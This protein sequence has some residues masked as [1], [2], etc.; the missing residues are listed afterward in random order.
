[1]R[2]P[3]LVALVAFALSAASSSAEAQ[4]TTVSAAHRAAVKRFM[5]VTRVRELTEQSAGRMLDDQLQQ[6]P[7]LAPLAG[8]LRDFYREQMSWTVLEPEYTRIY[9]EVFTE[10]ELRKLTEF[11]QT[12]LGKTLLAKTP[13]LM[14]KTA[15]VTTRRMQAALPQLMERLQTTMQPPTGTAPDPA[16]PPRL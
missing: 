14:S 3:R 8:V 16:P 10:P 12:P 9:L 6:M 11:Y 7:Q 13:V 5:E 4:Q 15:E 2:T 1:M